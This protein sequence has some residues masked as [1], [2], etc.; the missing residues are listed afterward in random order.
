VREWPRSYDDVRAEELVGWI[1][2]FSLYIVVIRGY[3]AAGG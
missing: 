2:H 1:S 3:V